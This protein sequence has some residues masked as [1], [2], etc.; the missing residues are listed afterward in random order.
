MSHWECGSTWY[1]GN[2]PRFL[3]KCVLRR[4]L[5]PCP[6]LK[7]MFTREMMNQLAWNPE[8]SILIFFFFKTW[9]IS[10]GDHNCQGWARLK[11]HPGLPPEWQRPKQLLFPRPLAVNWIRRG[12]A[13]TWTGTLPGK[14]MTLFA[15]SQYWPL[16]VLCL[17]SSQTGLDFGNGRINA[18][19]KTLAFRNEGNLRREGTRPFTSAGRCCPEDNLGM[20][21]GFFPETGDA[22]THLGWYL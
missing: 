9:R 4:G 2:Y 1:V 13:R 3:S 22:L 19:S 12:I 14:P 8:L 21:Y 15:T 20:L 11:L 10:P 6:F 7:L 17:I 18:V 16:L 5:L